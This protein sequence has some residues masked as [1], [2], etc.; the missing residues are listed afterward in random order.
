MTAKKS[1][2]EGSKALIGG[3]GNEIWVI[4]DGEG[5]FCVDLKLFQYSCSGVVGEG[6]VG[7]FTCW[8]FVTGAAILKFA[9]AEVI[10]LSRN[11]TSRR[12]EVAKKVWLKQGSF[13]R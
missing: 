13:L 2:L 6:P 10:G 4:V 9:L 11:S 1:L 12:V 8:S 5:I 7:S 3:G